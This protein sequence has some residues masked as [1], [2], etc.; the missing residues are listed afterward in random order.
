MGFVSVN[1]GWRQVRLCS[2]VLAVLM[3]TGCAS[4]PRYTTH[5]EFIAPQSA[6]GRTCVAICSG[7]QNSCEANR[8]TACHRDPDQCERRGREAFET[9]RSRQTYLGPQSTQST[10]EVARLQCQSEADNALRNCQGEIEVCERNAIGSC[11]QDYN[12]CFA[13]CGGQIKRT[14]VCVRNCDQ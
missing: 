7:N 4:G 8:R 10:H 3:I 6:E 13:S 14:Q 5:T 12:A 11:R 1:A 9:C 2:S